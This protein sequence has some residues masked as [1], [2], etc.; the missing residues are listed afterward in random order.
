MYHVQTYKSTHT[1]SQTSQIAQA[2]TDS[3]HAVEPLNR[4]HFGT[5]YFVLCRKVVLTLEV[6]NGLAIIGKVIVGTFKSVLHKKDYNN[7]LLYIWSVFI[8]GS[9]MYTVQIPP[10]LHLLPPS[11]PLPPLPPP[12]PLN[13]SMMCS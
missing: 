4:R 3:A 13:F 2:H 6:A 11:P 12:P 10:P 1:V 9:T 7:L 8:R 5:S